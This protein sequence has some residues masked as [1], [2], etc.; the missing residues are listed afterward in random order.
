MQQDQMGRHPL[1]LEISNQIVRLYKDQFGR[2]PTKA[3]TDWAGPD[4]L[5]CTLRDTLTPAERK[6]AALGEFQRL[7]ES[8]VFFQYANEDEFVEIV[9]SVTKRKVAAF[10]SGVD[11]ERD[12]AAEIFYFEPEPDSA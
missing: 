8:R 1:L 12:V 10:V 6:L 11:A 9:E 7:R 5:V 2:G 3:R 4:A